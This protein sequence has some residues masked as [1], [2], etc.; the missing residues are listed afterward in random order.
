[1]SSKIKRERLFRSKLKQASKS[2]MGHAM[3]MAKKQKDRMTA[4]S[5][6]GLGAPDIC[7]R[8]KYFI[9][10]GAARLAS[11]AGGDNKAYPKA[12]KKSLARSETA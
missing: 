5:P 11:K 7:A 10:S 2:F 1:L 12:R 3:A 4:P 9:A 6:P 8:D